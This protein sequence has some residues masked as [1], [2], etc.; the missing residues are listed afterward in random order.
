MT[1]H[2]TGLAY[3]FLS[4]ISATCLADS[5]SLP[6][7]TTVFSQNGKFG[8]TIRPKALTSQLDYFQDKVA[9]RDDAGGVKGLSANSP[10]AEVFSVSAGGRT[11]I[12]RFALR[13][14]VTPVSAVL[15]NDGAW[16]VTFD[17]WHSMGYGP[18]VVVIYRADG[19]VVRA[20]S[21]ED[22][23]TSE[24]LDVLPRSVSSRYWAADKIINEE[25]AELEL[26]VTRCR[27]WASD[28]N[29][30]PSII[31]IR[32]SD[33]VPVE[34][35]K[36]LLPHPVVE[37]TLRLGEWRV[38]T[39]AALGTINPELLSELSVEYPSP[40]R[41]ARMQGEITLTGRVQDDGTVDSVVVVRGLNP[42]LD[43]AASRSLGRLC[44]RPARCGGHV[45]TARFIATAHFEIR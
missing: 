13:N 16:L 35:K 7:E 12:V 33:G 22:I 31:A 15:S 23:L 32:L 42:L 43:A 17:D 3:L 10:H 44:F 39:C 21:L 40:A 38:D 20:L 11:P 25:A 26:Y 8:V 24:D 30:K 45:A 28:C 4:A 2:K 6:V 34:Q 19:T 37:A 1:H 14:E 27:S 36:D 29:D 5:W 18:N 41:K 9:G